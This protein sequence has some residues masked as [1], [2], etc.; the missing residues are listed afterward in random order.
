VSRLAAGCCAA[1]VVFRV[2]GPEWAVAGDLKARTNSAPSGVTEPADGQVDGDSGGLS[3]PDRPRTFTW[4]DAIGNV[5]LMVATT[6]T[7]DVT[8][9]FSAP[10][11]HNGCGHPGR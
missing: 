6:P 4:D 11:V 10:S 1:R 7:E 9:V 8:R 3:P 5:V 2:G